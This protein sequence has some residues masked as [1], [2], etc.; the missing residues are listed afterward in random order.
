MLAWNERR[1]YWRF[2]RMIRRMM[3]VLAVGLGVA[4]C[5]QSEK[6][7]GAKR[8]VDSGGV[9]AKGEV[10]SVVRRAADWQLANLG[11][12]QKQDWVRSTLYTGVMAAYRT[13]GDEKY[14]NEAIKWGDA[15]GWVE[16]KGKK[17]PDD[18][19]CAQVYAEI[20]RVKKDARYVEK[21][22]PSFDKMIAEGKRGREEWSW[23]DTLFMAPPGMV[24][25]TAVTGDLKYA[26]AEDP[27]WWDSVDF[28]YDKEER[29]FFRDKTFFEKRSK[30]G[31]KVFWSRGNGWVAAGTC[32]VLEYLPVDHPSRPRYVKLQQEMLDR[33]AGLQGEDGLWGMSLL[34]RE[35][36]PTGETSGSAFFAYAM[37]WG[38]NHGTLDREKYLPVVLRTWAALKRRVQADGKL[39]GVQAVAAGPTTNLSEGST[40]EY[41]VGAFL[42]LGEQLAMMSGSPVGR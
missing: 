3:V 33:I 13:T 21:V 26:A 19:C 20:A 4:A 41:A 36:W 6:G 10:V 16:Y 12:K 11:E 42:L 22:R 31:K 24:R 35:E 32:R 37:A 9:P 15:V 1:F 30:N 39:V 2:Q 8:G 7:S 34:D 17:R 28:L 27:M 29:L 23:C 14:L 38:I 25:L 5:A 18:Q 40:A